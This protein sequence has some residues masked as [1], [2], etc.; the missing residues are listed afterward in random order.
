[1][2]KCSIVSP[3]SVPLFIFSTGSPKGGVSG[4]IGNSRVGENTPDMWIFSLMLLM[5]ALVIPFVVTAAA[6]L[7]GRDLEAR[8]R[9][10]K[11]MFGVG[12]VIYLVLVGYTVSALRIKDDDLGALL[13]SV[14][15]VW[16][17]PLAS[18]GFSV[19]VFWGRDQPVTKLPD[20]GFS[21]H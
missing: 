17:I 16:G 7:T 15:M 18:S 3:S 19:L 12:S 2:R 8:R 6:G 1:M 11:F 21:S 13:M 10:L 14:M 4:S 20:I 5:I 9:R